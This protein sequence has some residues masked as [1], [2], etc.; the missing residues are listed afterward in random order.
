MALV[1]NRTLNKIMPRKTIIIFITVFIV[2]GAMVIGV[3]SYLNKSNT[4]QNNNTA[5]S[6][7]GG[8]KTFN[9]FGTGNTVTNNNTTENPTESNANNNTSDQTP[10]V[11]TVSKFQK[12]TDFAIAGAAF[13]EDTRPLPTINTDTP[14]QTTTGT[15]PKATKPATPKFENVPSIR[16]VERATGH[17]YQMYLDNKVI[18]Q[19]SNSTIPSIYEAIF[20][21]KA[22]SI[23]YRYLSTDGVTITSFL[24]TLGGKNSTFLPQNITALATSPDKS[25]FFYLTENRNGVVGTIA[26]FEDSK[27]SQVFSSPF[28]EWLPQWVGDK[29]VYI[30]T[31][32]SWQV[33]GDV[34][35]LNTSNGSISK[36]FGGVP[37]LTT[38]ANNNGSLILYNT[39][40]N[41]GPKLGLFNTKTN[42][43][44]DINAY[45]L[46]EK[47]V[48]SKD[49]I[50][51]Y[52]AIPRSIE[53]SEYP[54]NW[55]QGL[56]SFDDN[57]I[58][59]NTQTNG[60]GPVA[61]SFT[62]AP[63]DATNLFLD[64]KETTLFFTNKK[65]STLWSLSLQ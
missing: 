58:K 37:G 6:V 21:S 8:Y 42:K 33:N 63:M 1:N 46:P 31:K 43:P 44:S 41:S 60:I 62:Q 25:K 40:L 53:G 28:T 59:I 2:I 4:A 20:D 49:N 48:W 56:V 36:I 47:C 14:T 19:V 50:N 10:S 32:P 12:I 61:D 34:F 54:D 52:C 65:D 45:G 35:S 22:K 38:L 39:S 3:Y 9:P 29:T 55:Y 57:F 27:G 13:F 7:N 30:T 24:A 5:T 18:G 17:I 23:I 64:D 26:G 15:K 16:Y 51:V 11:T